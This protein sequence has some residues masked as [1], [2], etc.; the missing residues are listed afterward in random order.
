MK[1]GPKYCDHVRLVVDIST[2]SL[3][4]TITTTTFHVS[5]ILRDDFILFSFTALVKEIDS[6]NQ[7]DTN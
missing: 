3:L 5:N 1:P 4:I 7:V 2:F 6:E